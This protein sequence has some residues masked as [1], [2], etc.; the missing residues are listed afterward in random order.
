MILALFTI[1]SAKAL[2]EFA[3]FEN[4]LK[5]RYGDLLCSPPTRQPDHQS[6]I[7]SLKPYHA[8]YFPFIAL[9]M[10]ILLRALPCH[11]HLVHD[12]LPITSDETN[13]ALQLTESQ[14]QQLTSIIGKVNPERS[15]LRFVGF[16]PR[17]EIGLNGLSTLLVDIL[18]SLTRVES[19]VL[20]DLRT[21]QYAEYSD[22]REVKTFGLQKKVAERLGKSPVAIHKSLRSSKYHLIAEATTSM[23][24]MMD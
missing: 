20:A 1:H 15:L 14:E 8:G 12:L 5:A 10:M 19:E 2:P 3:R 17:I 18:E 21:L 23:R 13:R 4:L 22:P 9:D 24:G 6:W 16:G 7:T 11:L